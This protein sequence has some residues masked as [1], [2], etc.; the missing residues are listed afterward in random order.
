LHKTVHK[1][2]KF[3]AQ[4]ALGMH[5]ISAEQEGMLIAQ[6]CGSYVKEATARLSKLFLQSQ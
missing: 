6:P 2:N 4:V 3:L 5:K 1:V